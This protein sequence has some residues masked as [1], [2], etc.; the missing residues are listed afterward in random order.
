MLGENAERRRAAPISSA[1]EWK[2]FWNTARRR[3]SGGSRL[4]V[5]T[6]R[7]PGR[8]PEV[9]LTVPIDAGAPAGRYQRSRAVL[10]DHR[11]SPEAFT[12]AQLF[13][14][15]DGDLFRFAPKVTFSEAR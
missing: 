3:G 1:T 5:I 6:P 15:E 4:A 2:M 10:G 12:G 8:H 14:L 9:D 7:I 11:G 13:P